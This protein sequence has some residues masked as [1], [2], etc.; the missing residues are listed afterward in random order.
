MENI[1]YDI[2]WSNQVDDRFI[3]DFRHVCSVVFKNDFTRQEFDRK[4]VRNIYGP[5]VLVVVYIDNVPSAARALWRNDI[6]GKKA[7]QPADTCV[8]ENCRGKGVFSTMTKKSIELLP[9]SAIIYNFPNPQSY[10]GYIKM[11]W[12]LVHNYGMHLLGSYKQFAKEHP[13]K[14]DKEYAEWWI[15]GRNLLYTKYCNHYF[16]VQKDHRPLCH[17]ILAEVDKEVALQFP[18]VSFGLFFYKSTLT[19]WYSKRFALSHVVSCNS[20]INY[21]PTWKIDAV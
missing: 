3:S 6:S 15:K 17:R 2:R 12:K 13:I 19:T 1:I 18:H 9:K 16:L 8:M 10:P 4:F 11:G 21:I 5:S 7:Y 14:M 20:D